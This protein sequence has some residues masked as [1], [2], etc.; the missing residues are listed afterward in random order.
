[1]SA[2]WGGNEI[3]ELLT[4]RAENKISRH[5]E[6]IIIIVI[7]MLMPL[8]LFWTG[9]HQSKMIAAVF[10][11][12]WLF[13]QWGRVIHLYRVYDSNTFP[14]MF[15]FFFLNQCPVPGGTIRHT[16]IIFY[17]TAKSSLLELCD[18]WKVIFED[19]IWYWQHNCSSQ[20]P[21]KREDFFMHNNVLIYDIKMEIMK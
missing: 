12:F 2:N 5:L 17:L 3:Q 21:R 6:M 16:I 7:A 15:F 18:F 13:V 14:I 1:M 19:I 4:L 10:G 20:F 8:L 11:I 9:H